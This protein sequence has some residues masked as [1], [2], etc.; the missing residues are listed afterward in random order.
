M[1]AKFTNLLRSLSGNAVDINESGQMHTVLRG[2][3]DE[4]N[5]TTEN[6]IADEVFVGESIDTLDYSAVTIAINS[7]V[8]SS[9]DGL[10]IQYSDDEINWCCGETYTILAGANKF[11]TPTLQSKYMRVVYTNGTSETTTFRI[12]TT[13]RKS[14]IKWSSHNIDDPISD[15]DDAEL[16]KAVNTGRDPNGIYRNVNVT[17]DGDMS[18]SDNS[19]GLAIAKGLVTGTSYVSKF[20]QNEALNTS[21]YEDI[22]DGGGTY[23][24]PANGTAPITHLYSTGAD[25]QPIEVQG[26]DINGN[27]VVQTITLTGTTV[28]LLTT[29]LWRVFRMKNI[30]TIDILTGSVIHA[31]DAGKAVSYAQI[32]NGNNQTLMALYTIPAGKTG[33]LL[34]GSASLVGTTRAYSIDG[35]FYMRPYGGVFQLKHTFGVSSDGT[36]TFQHEYK[37]PLPINELTDLRVSAISSAAGGVLNSTF[38]IALV[39]N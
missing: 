12:N 16:V 32:Q 34:M 37:I 9:T 20:G 24:W 14:P 7:D 5:S 11:F 17:V 30:G 10:E 15:Q 6:L 18:I 29:P 3:I 39:D 25:V 33:Y 31:S 1:I 22:W 36:S 13:L 27:L 23:T 26:L 4:G 38:D 8:A 19:S 28:V 2:K 21:T 35:H